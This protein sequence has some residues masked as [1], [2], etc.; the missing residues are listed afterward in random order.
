MCNPLLIYCYVATAISKLWRNP[1]RNSYFINSQTENYTALISK[2]M[3]RDHFLLLTLFS[4][5][6]YDEYCGFR[7]YLTLHKQVSSR[8][9]TQGVEQELCKMVLQTIILNPT[10]SRI[11][12]VYNSM[13]LLKQ[14]KLSNFFLRY[15]DCF[16]LN[17]VQVNNQE[18]AEHIDQWES[19][20][21]C[22]QS[23]QNLL[24]IDGDKSKKKQM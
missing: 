15:L 8:N 10:F 7:S 4:C 18:I 12:E 19:R 23:E 22:I 17:K 5:S 16:V 21:K 13:K 24:L 11:A 20:I 6:F 14:L 1:I 3:L 9:S 2:T